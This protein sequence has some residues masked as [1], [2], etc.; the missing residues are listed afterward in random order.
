MPRTH[1]ASRAQ[2]Q[3]TVSF[4][5]VEY[6]KDPTAA[7][8]EAGYGHRVELLDADGNPRVVIYPGSIAD[9]PDAD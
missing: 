7:L 1:V 8:A 2:Q 3:T 6:L 5:V 4:S 9:V